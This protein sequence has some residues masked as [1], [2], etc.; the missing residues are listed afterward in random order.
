M[1]NLGTN[2]EGLLVA[3]GGATESQ[4][5]SNQVLD[6]YDIGASAWT[7]QA[8]QGF[9]LSSRVNHCAVR[10]SAI[11]HGQVRVLLTTRTMI[12]NFVGP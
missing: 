2:N 4:Y 10:A 3:I 12:M 7:K 8:T 11:V 5:V 6:V 9:P 1:P